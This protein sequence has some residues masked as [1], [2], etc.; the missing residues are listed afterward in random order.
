MKIYTRSGDQGET[1]LLAGQR[2]LKHHP[3]IETCGDL[4]ETNSLI[5]WARAVGVS[6]DFDPWLATI[7]AALFVLGARVAGWQ[8]A[9]PSAVDS[10]AIA[11]LERQIDLLTVELPPLDHFILP[12]GTPSGAI[13]HAAR[14]VCRRAE[15]RLVE[16]RSTFATQDRLAVELVY[17]N[18]LSDWLFTLARAENFRRHQ[19]ETRWTGR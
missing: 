2:V 4:D 8:S 11:E 5:G 9:T 14:A 13:L 10:A 12:G 6:P 18:R 1:G 16:L 17:I 7:Q 3:A 19:P 15:R